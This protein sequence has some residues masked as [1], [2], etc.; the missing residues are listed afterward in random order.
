[1]DNNPLFELSITSQA[2]PFPYAPLA[3]AIYIN[4]L[5][6]KQKPPVQQ[7]PIA[8]TPQPGANHGAALAASNVKLT[9]KQEYPP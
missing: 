7:S 3:A 1:M 9:R 4:D 8:I 2:K 5:S 6:K